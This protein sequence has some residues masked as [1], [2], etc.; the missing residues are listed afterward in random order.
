MGLSPFPFETYS[1]R[2]AHAPQF[3]LEPQV[4]TG[5]FPSR[6]VRCEA[7]A[8]LG[9]CW[10]LRWAPVPFSFETSAEQGAQQ[11][12][13]GLSLRWGPAPSPS[14][15]MRCKAPAPLGSGWSLR[16]AQ[17]LP[18][19][20]RCGTRRPSRSGLAGDSDG[21]VCLTGWRGR[22]DR[23]EPDAAPLGA[24]GWAALNWSSLQK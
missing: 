24:G 9:S 6:P 14:R 8:P 3:L 7:P 23:A 1:V 5:S 19:R 11:L 2:G 12:S 20:D 10:S 16:W 21:S 13:S 18:L 4:G 17:P 22:S 15:P